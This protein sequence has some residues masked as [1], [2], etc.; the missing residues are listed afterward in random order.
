MKKYLKF[1]YIFALVM[2]L[3]GGTYLYSVSAQKSIADKVIRLHVIANSDSDAD[4]SLKLSVR[5]EILA[6]MGDRMGEAENKG[7]AKKII[8]EKLNEIEIIS[9]N[10]IKSEG[11][12]YKAKAS[13]AEESFPLKNYGSFYFP[14][15]NYT[16]LKVKIG[17]AKG[18]NWWCVMFPPLCMT[19]ETVREDGEEILGKA[20]SDRDMSL[21]CPDNGKPSVKVKFFIVKK[22]QEFFGTL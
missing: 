22:W 4:Q 10:I 5:D 3:T 14:A 18:K 13:I 6:F 21:V 8:E 19:D 12:D 1:V 7:D 16:A 15:G 2:L 20:L 9:E 17:E 11:F